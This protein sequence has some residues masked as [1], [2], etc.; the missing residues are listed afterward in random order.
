MWC[1]GSSGALVFACMQMCEGIIVQGGQLVSS[2]IACY[3]TKSASHPEPR[4]HRL[5]S[6]LLQGSVLWHPG[7]WDYRLASKTPCGFYV[8]TGT[9]NHIPNTVC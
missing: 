5:P 7:C 2:A 6:L 3:F 9:L 1:M 8:V 4:A